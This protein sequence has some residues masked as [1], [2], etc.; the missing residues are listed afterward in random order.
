MN[1]LIKVFRNFA[2]R[3]RERVEKEIVQRKNCL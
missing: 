1:L 2:K 3:E